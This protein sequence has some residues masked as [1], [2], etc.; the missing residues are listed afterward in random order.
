MYPIQ[1]AE[2]APPSDSLVSMGGGGE[3]GGG[4]TTYPMQYA[5]MGP[6][7]WNWQIKKS[8][9]KSYDHAQ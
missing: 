1:Y 5:E 3:R 2:K 7:R 6:E 8:D 4:Q 9:W